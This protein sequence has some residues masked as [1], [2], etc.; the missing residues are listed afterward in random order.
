M[1]KETNTCTLPITKIWTLD[2]K[3]SLLSEIPS[4]A[5]AQGNQEVQDAGEL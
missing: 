1:N 2:L 3:G 4:Q 5:I